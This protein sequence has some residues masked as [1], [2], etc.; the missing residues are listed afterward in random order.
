LGNKN[1]VD[2]FLFIK[3]LQLSRSSW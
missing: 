2:R 3:R 1:W